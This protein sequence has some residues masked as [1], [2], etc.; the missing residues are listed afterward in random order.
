M[1][2]NTNRYKVM[3]AKCDYSGGALPGVVIGEIKLLDDN[4][5][6]TYMC[7]SEVDGLPNWFMTDRST[8][9]EQ[10]DLDSFDNDDFMSYMNTHSMGLGNYD[11]ALADK[12][13]KW[14]IALRYLTYLVRCSYED[15]DDFIANTLGKY[16]DEISIPVSDVEENLM[17]DFDDE[18]FDPLDDVDITFP[19]DKESLF[20]MC[21]AYTAEHDRESIFKD[22]SP[23][24]EAINEHILEEVRKLIDENEYEDWKQKYLDTEY[25]KLKDHH[26][27]VV[28]YMFA[29]FGGYDDVIPEEQFDSFICWI[30]GNGS[31]FFTGKRDAE[32]DDVKQYIALHANDDDTAE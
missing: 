29:G 27:L 24:D 16:L 4:G 14:H 15:M 7:N 20:R 21:L 18:E 10:M 22:L 31:A 30:N 2:K 19:E 8:F 25:D 32:E 9:E 12:H 11:E 6:V 1:A 3:D 5:N 17:E 13:S 26:F 23:E 28:S